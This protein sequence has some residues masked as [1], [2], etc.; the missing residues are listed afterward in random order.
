MY[1]VE[2]ELYLNY[3]VQRLLHMENSLDNF[4]PQICNVVTYFSV[5]ESPGVVFLA[6]KSSYR[7][8]KQGL[9]HFEKKKIR[10]LWSL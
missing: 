3:F 4:P 1:L 8:L 7:Q 10:Y 9:P 6:G 5:V 2:V